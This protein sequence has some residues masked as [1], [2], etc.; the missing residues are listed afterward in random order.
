M[1]SRSSSPRAFKVPELT[2]SRVEARPV[3]HVDVVTNVSQLRHLRGE[4]EALEAASGTDLPFHTWEWATCWWEHFHEDRLAVRDSLRIF[5][6]RVDD[7]LVGVAPCMLTERPSIGP[8]RVR[9]LQFLGADPNLTEIRGLL[10]EPRH[11]AECYAALGRYFEAH[12]MEWDWISWQGLRPDTPVRGGDAASL[13][14]LDERLAYVVDLPPTWDE[15]LTGLHRSL[16]G[17]LRRFRRFLTEAEHQG[18]LEIV[19][20]PAEVPAAVEDFCRLYAARESVKGERGQLALF[21]SPVTQAFL[22]DVCER[23]A[24]RG[25]VKVFRYWVDDQLVATRVGFQL[26]DRLYLYYSGWDSAWT[27]FSV[28][29]LLVADAIEYAIGAGLKSVHLSTGRDQSKTRWSP[30][31]VRYLGGDQIE[32]R[33]SAQFLHAVHG[34]LS[35]FNETGVARRVVAPLLARRQPSET[36]DAPMIQWRPPVFRLHG[37][38]AGVTALIALDLIDRVIDHAVRFFPHV[39]VG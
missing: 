37:V 21:A 9:Y 17:N 18:R 32:P 23:L 13:A 25:V 26:G 31:E 14:A 16:R 3:W 10:C 30:R 28:M 35:R 29:T 1:L 24:T 34:R 36:D 19:E 2:E 33:P 6:I 38:S 5:V 4:W 15:F 39:L 12:G 20:A 27:E 11:E 22:I 7:T 8:V